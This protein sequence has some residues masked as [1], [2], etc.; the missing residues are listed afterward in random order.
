MEITTADLWWLWPLMGGMAVL[1]AGGLVLD[2]VQ[3]SSFY[4]V[5]PYGLAIG[6]AIVLGLG[7]MAQGE[8][9]ILDDILIPVGIGLLITTGI[10]IS[11]SISEDRFYPNVID[12]R[13]IVRKRMLTGMSMV[14]AMFVVV[15][16]ASYVI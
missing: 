10:R 9:R 15:I 1:V 16:S 11:S 5:G 6:T 8:Y 2:L 3:L 13:R 12:E 7:W 14:A 4:K